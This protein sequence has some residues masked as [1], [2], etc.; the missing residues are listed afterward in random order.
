MVRIQPFFAFRPRPEIAEKIASVPYDVVNTEEARALADGNPLSFLRVIRPEIDLPDGT[1][2]Y[3]DEVYAAAGRNLRKLLDEGVLIRDVRRCLYLYRQEATLLGRQVSQSGV[4]ACC[5]VGDYDAGLIKKHEKTR[6]HKEDDRTR[7]VLALNANAG[8]VFLLHRDRPAIK[9]LIEEAQLEQPLYD[10]TASD[11]VRHTVW[12]VDRSELLVQAFAELDHAYVAD[13][14][15]RAA[16]AARAGA[17]RRKGNPLHT[18]SEEYNWFLTVLFGAEQLTIL[19]YHRLVRDLNG[20]SAESFIARLMQIGTLVPTGRP[21]VVS[22]GAFSVFAGGKWY[23]VRMALESIA[24]DDP[25]RSLDY[26]LLDERV[27]DPVLGIK[28]VR[29]DSRIDF[30]GGIRGTA[31]LE[32]RVSS[33]EMAAAFAMR[34]IK[35]EQLMRVADAGEIMPPKSTWFEPKLRSGLLIHSLD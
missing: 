9:S 5:H 35:V 25:V 24:K 7:H 33:G 16:S 18:G 10:F 31:E 4:V 32:R 29:S 20:L 19:P 17:A 11:C 1:D 27:L 3:A 23:R 6:Q 34:P 2:P 30:V 22:S 8:P 12:R 14:H 15:H 26:V 13:G 21:E 28:D